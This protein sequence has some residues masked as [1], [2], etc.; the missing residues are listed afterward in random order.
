MW[1]YDLEASPTR[2]IHNSYLNIKY[3]VMN[4]MNMCHFLSK[5]NGVSSYCWLLNCGH[6]YNLILYRPHTDKAFPSLKCLFSQPKIA[7]FKQYKH[8]KLKIEAWNQVNSRCESLKSCRSLKSMR[9]WRKKACLQCLRTTKA[10]TSLHIRA[11]WSVHLLFTYW[12]V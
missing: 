2:D 12:K 6:Q 4:Y 11:V 10:Q 9:P 8:W 3:F 1:N 7:F 5:Y